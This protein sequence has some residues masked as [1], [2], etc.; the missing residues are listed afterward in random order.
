MSS[1]LEKKQ[2]R[3]RARL[4]HER[5][6]ARTERRS[7]LIKRS[8][9]AAAVV[10]VAGG[11]I[12]LAIVPS[13]DERDAQELTEASEAPFGQHYDG[14]SERVDAAIPPEKRTGGDHEH[15]KL[16]V[17]ANGEAVPVPPNIGISPVEAGHAPM[18]THEADGTIHLEGAVDATLGQF[19]QIWGVPLTATRIGPYQERGD[20]AVR[21]WVDGKPSQAFGRLKLA[22]GQQIVIAYGDR[23]AP[24]PAI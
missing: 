7:R 4:E 2:R 1:R 8:L 22:D 21:M 19:F 3:K 23:D 12:A 16:A 10:S 9:A 18:H 17:F 6:L 13:G 11:L 14:L 24:A 20:Q 5:E 15:P